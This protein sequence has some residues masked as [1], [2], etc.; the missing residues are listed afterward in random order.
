MCACAHVCVS[1]LSVPGPLPMPV[2]F[3]CACMQ[4]ITWAWACVHLA[5]TISAQVL[6]K[7]Y[8]QMNKMFPH[9]PSSE[10]R[11]F[12]SGVVK[13]VYGAE[14]AVLGD[15]SSNPSERSKS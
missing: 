5:M 2:R 4:C 3:L 14:G 1:V 7:L 10:K 12:S 8:T 9:S 13:R 11:I 15:V 6:R